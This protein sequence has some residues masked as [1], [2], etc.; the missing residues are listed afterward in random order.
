[1]EASDLNRKQAQRYWASL[2]LGILFVSIVL[3]CC[4]LGPFVLIIYIK[5]GLPLIEATAHKSAASDQYAGLATMCFVVGGATGGYAA[6]A[7]WKRIV[8]QTGFVDEQTYAR[9]LSGRAPTLLGERIRKSIGYVLY[10]SMTIGLMVLLYRQ[11]GL[12]WAAVPFAFLLYL[13]YLTWR[14]FSAKQ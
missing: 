9:I 14:S 13:I 10:Y 7:L 2:F 6:I 5:G 11:N 3:I 8:V 1:M 12:L 4:A